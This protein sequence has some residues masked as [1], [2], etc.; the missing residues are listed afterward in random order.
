MLWKSIVV[1]SWSHAIQGDRLVEQIQSVV[2]ASHWRYRPEPGETQSTGSYIWRNWKRPGSESNRAGSS[3]CDALD[4]WRQALSVFAIAP[5]ITVGGSWRII[6]VRFVQVLTIMNIM[7]EHCA[8]NKSNNDHTAPRQSKSFPT[9]QSVRVNDTGRSGQSA[10]NNNYN[11]WENLYWFNRSTFLPT[12][13]HNIC[14]WTKI[15]R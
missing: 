4:R 13:A 11:G 6:H 5:I 7:G 1:I 2:V 15:F 9:E 3:W 10:F 8:E 12:P 14:R